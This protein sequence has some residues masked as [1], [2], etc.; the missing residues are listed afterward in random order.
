MKAKCDKRSL[1]EIK[2]S[3][4]DERFKDSMT[5]GKKRR[6]QGD[7]LHIK[8]LEHNLLVNSAV[9]TLVL[10]YSGFQLSVDY[11]YFIQ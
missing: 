10:T 7:T 1:H 8:N 4:E 11:D 2:I 3:Y 5:P 9:Y 6:P